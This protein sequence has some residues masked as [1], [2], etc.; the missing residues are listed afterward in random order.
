V[1]QEG[2]NG[3]STGKAEW[4]IGREC[5]PKASKK[6]LLQEISIPRNFYS[7]KFLFQ[8]TFLVIAMR[9]DHN[10]ECKIARVLLTSTF[11]LA[12]QSATLREEG[13]CVSGT[14]K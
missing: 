11:K 13:K 10:K 8:E 2:R 5:D 12:D 1:T 14:W 3:Q 9:V 6:L 4:S 7:K